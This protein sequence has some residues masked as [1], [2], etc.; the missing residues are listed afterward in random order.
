MNLI[1]LNKIKVKVKV[2]A[3]SGVNAKYPILKRD[4]FRYVEKGFG[5]LSGGL[6]LLSWS[7]GL[8]SIVDRGNFFEKL[9]LMTAFEY[10][11]CVMNIVSDREQDSKLTMTLY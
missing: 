3:K 11:I 6:N 8:K 9:T 1:N 4:F 2:E 7:N 10:F 5:Y